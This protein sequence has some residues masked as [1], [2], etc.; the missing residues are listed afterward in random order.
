VPWL[1]YHLDVEGARATIEWNRSQ[2]KRGKGA[3]L[4]T[5]VFAFGAFQLASAFTTIL[6][7]GHVGLPGWLPWAAAP[8]G[9]LAAVRMNPLLRWSSD[10]Y[11]LNEWHPKEVESLTRALD[12]R[13]PQFSTGFVLPKLEKPLQAWARDCLRSLRLI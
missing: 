13:Y 2:A 7:I 8:L 10:A 4:M 3:M 11:S 1:R 5:G 12:A 6:K 9:A